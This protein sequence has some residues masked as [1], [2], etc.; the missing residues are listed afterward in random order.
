MTC[1]GS[2]ILTYLEAD[3]KLQK[4]FQGGHL[5]LKQKKQ[6]FGDIFDH[7]NFRNEVYRRF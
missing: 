7:P 1:A 6:K 5:P 3:F 4:T 2:G